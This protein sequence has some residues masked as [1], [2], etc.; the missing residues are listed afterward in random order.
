VNYIKSAGKLVASIAVSFAAGGLGSLATIPNIP[1]WYT[2]LDKPPL[3]PPNEVF[4]PVWSVLYLLMGI[5]LFLVWN[6]TTESPALKGY[7]AFGL[8]IVLNTVWSIVF[9]GL[10]LPW[11]GVVVIIGL[12]AAIVWTILEFKKHS[13]IAALLLVPYLLWVCFATYLTLGVAFLN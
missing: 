2:G 9:F 10:H 4:G 11:L 5:A 3:L 13:K 8:Q 1:S 7:Y 12:I 6:R